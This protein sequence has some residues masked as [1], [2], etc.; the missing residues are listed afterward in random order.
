MHKNSMRKYEQGVRKTAAE[1][2]YAHF[3]A[4]GLCDVRFII[5][6]K[7]NVD[8]PTQREAFWV[9]KLDTVCLYQGVK[10]IRDFD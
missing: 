7:T 5:I 3:L 4:Q 6:N 8:I 1:H 10:C 9:Y 2:L